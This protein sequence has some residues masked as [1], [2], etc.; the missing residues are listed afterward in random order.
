MS[1]KLI[2]ALDVDRLDRV[3][4]I[5]DLLYPEVEIFKVG[6]QLF[7][8]YGP[9]AVKIVR[10]KGADVFLDLKFH[11]IPNTVAKSERGGR[12]GGEQIRHK[13]PFDYWSYG[14][15]KSGRG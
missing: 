6:S 15:D 7:T 14:I 5:V 12:F 8:L 10:K 2:V 11:D 4:K 3:K 1:T 13:T 9:E